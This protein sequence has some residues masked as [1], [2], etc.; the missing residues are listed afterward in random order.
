MSKGLVGKTVAIAAS[1]KTEEM[2]ALVEKQ[3]GKAVVRP[4]QGTTFLADNEIENEFLKVLDDKPDWL[5]FTTG[6]GTETLLN[7]SEHLNRKN[8]FEKLL[9]DEKIAARGYKTHNTLKKI[10][11]APEARD[12]DGT[13]EGL[14]NAMKN[15]DFK[16]KNVMVQLHGVKAPRLVDFL[17]NK[18][19]TSVTEIL[20]YQHIP[21]EEDTLK[22][23]T[24]ELR[25]NELDAVCFTTQLQVHS[26]FQYAK[27]QG[28][29]EELV[30]I[31][32]NQTVAAA[33]GK[34]TAEV[35]KEEGVKRLLSPTNQRMGAMI[36]EL[37][38]L[39]QNN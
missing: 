10:G 12:D 19:A 18:D 37:S 23:I 32:E 39:H 3:G 38:K 13:T 25:R 22:L 16:N 28:F 30:S 29:K 8:D 4:L 36:M 17:K 6:I 31:F 26:L 27:Q 5:I 15:K 9:K 1:R 34:V 14:I 35:L 11:V 21:P 7:L 24:E 33:V 2:S 20:P